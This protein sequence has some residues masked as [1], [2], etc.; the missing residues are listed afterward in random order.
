[1]RII[2]ISV[3]LTEVPRSLFHVRVE[4]PVRPNSVAIFTTPVWIQESHRDN[5]PIGGVAGLHFSSGT[6]TLKWRRNPKVVSE[7]LVHVPVGVDTVHASFDAIVT[8][9][10]TRRIA[11]LNWEHVLMYPAQ[12]C[13]DKTFIRASVT[14]PKAWKVATALENLGHTGIVTDQLG[15]TKTLRYQPSSVERLQDSPILAGLYFSERK[16]SPDGRHVVCIAADTPEYTIP[17]PSVYNKLVRLTLETQ[18]AFGNPHYERYWWL[19]ALT[20][21]LPNHGGLEHHECSLNTLP[22]KVFVD[23]VDSRNVGRGESLL[24]HEFVH[25]WNG[26]YRRPKGHAPHDF[27]TPLDGRLLWVYEG[28]STYYQDVL[29]VR[30]AII[31]PEE[32]RAQLART[33]AWLEGQTGRLWRSI[34]DTGTGASL[35]PSAAW[36][37]WMRGG[38]DYYKEGVLVWLDVDTLIRSQTENIHSLDDFT[39]IFFGKNT[40]DRPQVVLYTLEDMVSCLQQILPYKW[41][42]FFQTRVVDVAPRVNVDGVER[43]GYRLKYAQEPGPEDKSERAT[44]EAIWNSVGIDLGDG[45]RLEDV[46]RGGP[47][48]LAKLAPGQTIIK[49]ADSPFTLQRLADEIKAKKGKDTGGIK[50]SL[51]HQDDEWMAELIYHGGMRYPRLVQVG[52]AHYMSAILATRL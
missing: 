3:D 11:V 45:G 46:K 38:Q 37:N 22:L 14:V 19:I 27:S 32:Y 40:A 8:K 16:L 30:S 49:V 29:S 7:Y 41:K 31:S 9:N 39:R 15:E 13:I 35:R 51:A 43:A 26:K 4:L 48:D 25:S 1:M 42:A 17:P 5:G 10:V 20:D 34:E 18:K 47:G 33:V 21:Y 2:H 50:L 24:A 44:K 52:A 28:L 23:G 36:A 6:E 12:R